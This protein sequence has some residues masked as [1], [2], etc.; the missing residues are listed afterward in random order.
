MIQEL[1]ELLSYPFVQ[2]MLI[3]GFLASLVGGVIGTY[4]VVNRVVVMSGG[5]AHITF[6]GI[7]LAYLLQD[8]LNWGWMDPMFGA[9]IFALASGAIFSSDFVQSRVRQDS[10]V[11]VLWVIGMATG[12][13]FLNLVDKTSTTV[14]EPTSILFGNILLIEKFDLYVFAGLTVGILVI[15]LIFFRD[16]KILTFDEEFARISGLN[17]GGLNLL[18]F[19]LIA[20]TVV[21]LIKVV[22]VILVIAML[23]IPP[24]ISSLFSTK[25]SSTMALAV[26][27]GLAGSFLGI[28]SSLLF[29]TPPGPMIVL[30]L[31]GM[32]LPAFVCGRN[33][34]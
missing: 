1:L 15:V 7:G 31:G 33:F 24:T 4:V 6:G 21:I 30:W 11:G 17:A 28:F 23:T 34:G 26:V 10:T 3:A 5:I 13:L 32:F 8:K 12:I 29:D 18:L 2:R 27:V 19:S 22:G 20:L 25:L 9:V 16:F 14:Q